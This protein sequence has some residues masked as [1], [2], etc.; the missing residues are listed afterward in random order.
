MHFTMDSASIRS[1]LRSSRLRSAAKD[2][3]SR[4]ASSMCCKR[5]TSSLR[6]LD[7]GLAQ[8]IVAEIGAEIRGSPQIDFAAEE[9]R[10]LSLDLRHLDQPDAVSRLKL[11]EH[12]HVAVRP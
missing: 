3:A 9:I 7:L 5:T 6:I 1:R 8:D 11:H 4:D 10:E 2:M 12:V